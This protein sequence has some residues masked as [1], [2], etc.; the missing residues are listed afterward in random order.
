MFDA[1]NELCGVSPE[2]FCTENVNQKKENSSFPTVPSRK[3]RPDPWPAHQ[4]HQGPAASSRATAATAASCLGVRGMPGH[5][6][7]AYKGRGPVL[8]RAL[9]TATTLVRHRLAQCR[10]RPFTGPPP[11]R[12]RLLPSGSIPPG[13]VGQSQLLHELCDDEPRP[14]STFPSPETLL[15]ATATA[16]RC[17]PQQPSTASHLPV[18]PRPR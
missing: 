8:L 1:L 18:S 5:G 10:R 4:T 14:S 13:C 9:D 11:S 3:A 15:S 7:R 17:R 2:F 12:A 6:I 16:D